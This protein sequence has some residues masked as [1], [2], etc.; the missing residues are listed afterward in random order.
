[1]NYSIILFITFFHLYLNQQYQLKHYFFH[2]DINY[3]L[4][5]YYDSYIY[6]KDIFY[7]GRSKS[8]DN[9]THFGT[10]EVHELVFLLGENNI[11]D[12]EKSPK[13]IFIISK[14]FTNKLGN[15]HRK[16]KIF[17]IDADQYSSSLYF[18]DSIFCLIGKKLDETLLQKL[19]KFI[20][21]SVIICL[22]IFCLNKIMTKII[23]EDNRLSIH[24]LINNICML[25]VCLIFSNGLGF[26]FDSL[27]FNNYLLIFVN[28]IFYSTLK[29][30]YYSAMC[31]SLSGDMILSFN[32]NEIIF[33]KIKKGAIFCS[34]FLTLLIKVFTYFNNLIT[35]LKLLCIKSILEHSI[36]LCCTIYF[37]NK[38]FLPLYSQVKYEQTIDSE[39]V[40]CLKFKFQRMLWLNVF[41]FIYNIF[42]IVSTSIELDHI[43][44]YIDNIKIHLSLQ[45]FYES[46]FCIF[47][48]I[49]FLPIKLPRYY[50]DKVIFNYEIY[51]NSDNLRVNISTKRNIS[52]LT[53]K[54]LKKIADNP[55]VFYNPYI[56]LKNQFSN[57]GLYLGIVQ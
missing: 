48:F 53:S 40:Q 5:L 27:V 36:L 30:F 15:K 10:G 51:E 9:S 33:K 6:Q 45:L 28:L 34:I 8:I 42:F 16:Y 18:R 31:F 49:I 29:G 25:L 4:T 2:L 3:N 56:S 46:V 19:R 52:I 37:I 22:L 47:F 44:F 12:I 1:M 41:M 55:I 57:N 7:S 50:F 54:I 35:E 17:I 24:I 23:N 39:L 26:I 20:Y 11:N 13:S 43:Y 38:K 21:S 14:D 32:E